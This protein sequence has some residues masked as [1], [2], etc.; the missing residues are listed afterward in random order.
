MTSQRIVFAGILIAALSLAACGGGDKGAPADQSATD[1]AE[2]ASESAPDTEAPAS[3]PAAD[4]TLSTAPLDRH[5]LLGHVAETIVETAPCPFLSDE[6]AVATAKGDRELPRMEVSNEVCRWAENAGFAVRV[7]V[8]PLATATPLK[9]RAYNLDT[10]PVLKPQD[11]P[12]EN[13]VILHDTAFD[14]ERPYAIGFEQDGKLVEIFVTGLA[15]DPARLTAAAEE[16][17]AKLPTAP[18]IEPQRR[19]IRPALGICTIWSPETL[20]ALMGVTGDESVRGSVYGKAGCKWSSGYGE[21]AKSVTLARYGQGDTDLDKVIER[22]GEALAG[23]GDRAVISTR[24][25][26]DGYSGDT[27]LLVEV[28]D[29]QFYLM[30]PGTVDNHASLAKT[31]MENLM[32]RI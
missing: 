8:E 7:S 4:V 18:A 23:L 31:L 32:S 1:T 5:A 25:P 28:D 30:I 16:V 19:E 21:T 22:G 2:R 27:S 9:D 20:G 12:G 6:T 11:G 14:T 17:S 10:P 26:A 13:A 3:A 29:Q 15:T 24:P